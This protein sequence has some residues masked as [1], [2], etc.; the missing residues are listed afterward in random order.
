MTPLARCPRCGGW[1]RA[2][3]EHLLDAAGAWRGGREP[4]PAMRWCTSAGIVVRPLPPL[5]P[6]PG[7][8]WRWTPAGYRR[9][10][11]R[12]LS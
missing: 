9:L 4:L 3:D 8:G 7:V 10:G 2:P 11:G 6:L 12:V 1:T 5:P